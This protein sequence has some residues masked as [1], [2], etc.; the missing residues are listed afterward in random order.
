MSTHHSFFAAA[1]RGM[2][3]LLDAELRALGA[4]RVKPGRAG[5][6]FEGPLA[7]AY[8]VCLWS[9]LAN[10]VLLTLARFAAP[11]AEALYRAVRELPWEDHL[12]PDGTLAVDLH[13]SD[14]PIRHS[15]FAALKVKDA[16]VDRLRERFGRRPSVE[17]DRPDL[18]INVYLRGPRAV[19]SLDLAG[20]SLH[21]RGYRERGVAAPLKENLAAAILLH[22]DWP[23]VAAGGGTLLD[24]MC[25]SGTL[26]IEA[27]LMA[28]DI[29]P[30]LMREYF[31]FVG[32]RG[33]DAPAWAALRD[34]AE[35]RRAAGLDR[36]AAI[37]GYDTD[38]S[39]V[40]AALGNVERAG[41]HGRIH[42]ERRALNEIDLPARAGAAP[43][44]VVVNPPYGE[45]LGRADTVAE[46]YRELGEVLTER[47]QG[48]QAAVFM[49]E[50]APAQA[51]GFRP[52]TRHSLYNG[53][54]ACTLS[55]FAVA[56]AARQTRGKADR[57]GAAP[58]PAQDT[59]S[60]GA[61][62]LANRL[63]KNLRHLGRWAR[64][65]GVDCYRLYD[66]DLPE[67]AVA[68]DLYQ[69]ERLWVHVQEYA[70]PAKVDPARAEA[71]GA[72]AL[73]VIA[74]VLEVA[75]DQVFYKMRRRQKGRAQYEKLGAGGRFHEVREG[76]CRLLVNFS[77]YLDT[78]LFLDHRLTR[79]LIGEL[80]QGRRFLNLFAYT[81]AA[82]V[83]AAVGGARATTSVDLS[84]TYLDWTRR[85]LALNGLRDG[86]HE[87]VQ[88][89]CLDWLEQAGGDPQR[90]YGLVFLDP[91]SFSTSKR[92]EATLDIQRDHVAL[93][94]A[95]A[96]LLTADGTLVFSTNLRRFKLDRPA[97]EHALPGWHVEDIT[98]ATLPPDFER[99]PRIHQCYRLQPDKG[100]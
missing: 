97:V 93:I 58:A 88:A 83:H 65:A 26:P 20:E 44:L 33:H 99:N 62:A 16:V 22:A 15:H 12:H 24:P 53:R 6:G 42:I 19:L 36:L 68:V 46:L 13:A 54:I 60:P 10:R 21:R 72:E 77:D 45:R 61:R 52:R 47:F 28:G 48:W 7:L 79:E 23:R 98:R 49:A 35:A 91:P 43:G 2:E 63:R 11:D 84:R 87:L 67:Y 8:R 78:G 1:P 41:L 32:W 75:P 69:G 31:G 51:L 71:R 3:A 64:R 14:S 96:R 89:D 81:G 86:D 17:L 94:A 9:R 34:E 73:A 57:T 85:N 55:L 5:V 56:P 27:A 82:T 4:E 92:M 70:P 76:P 18:R 100:P 50:E 74:E 40:R 95:A 30:G 37:I 90:R 39:A 80:A 29:A 25:G 66:A 38:A 59:S